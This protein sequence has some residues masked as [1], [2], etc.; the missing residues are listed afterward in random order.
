MKDASSGKNLDLIY[1]GSVK[2]VW[3]P[4]TVGLERA[5]VFK[6]SDAF[7]VFDWGRL[8]DA[9]PKKGS[10]LAVLTAQWFTELEKP[11]SWREFSRSPDALALRRGNRFGSA[12]MELGEKLQAEGLRTHFLGVWQGGQCV[13]FEDQKTP[14]D[15]IVVKQVSVSPPEVVKVLGREVA[16]YSETFSSDFPRLVPLEVV[17]RFGVPFG[18]SLRDR[19]V[20]DPTYLARRGFD[21]WAPK[22]LLPQTDARWDFPTLE[23]FTKLESRDRP[24]EPSEALQ[25]SGLTGAQLE[26]LYFLTAWTA[27]WIRWR[28]SLANTQL[29]DGKLEWGVD[30]RGNLFLVD[31]IG[32]DELRLER[33]GQSLSKEFLRNFYRET[34]WFR[35]VK[36]AKEKAE[37]AGSVDWKRGVKTPAPALS[38][39]FQVVATELYRSLTNSLTGKKWFPEAWSLDSVVEGMKKLTGSTQ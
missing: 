13:P 15:S 22:G 38:E 21:S 11:E 39:D 10:A 9:L 17:F 16:D 14:F 8:P 12:F 37:A 32:P 24:L 34:D 20:S 5:V 25:I 1:T 28:A 4:L 18:A 7:S 19:L 33:G 3:A 31:A 30:G 36:Q 27:G 35:D 2:E 23:A 6:Y 26:K 29:G